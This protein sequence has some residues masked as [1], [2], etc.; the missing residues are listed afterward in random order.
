[1][2]SMAFTQN[3]SF[4]GMIGVMVIGIRR[5]MFSN[6]AGMGNAAIV[7]A[8]SKT[9]EPVREGLVAMLGPF[10]D[11]IIVCV[12][13]ALVVILTGVWNQPAFTQQGGDIGVTLTAAAFRSVI[14]WFPYILTLCIVLFAYSTMI[15]WCYY[16][17]RG[18]IYLLDQC[19]G[20]GL[21]TVVIFR[22]L[23]VVFVVIGA[24][25]PLRDVLDFSDAMIFSMAFPNI[26][27]SMLLAPQVRERV[28]AYWQRIRAENMPVMT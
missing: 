14:P 17:E 22:I 15:S 23:F 11:T 1:M 28:H 2:V 7:H 26:L 27:G 16:G 25:N 9:D 5:A 4:G 20:N 21:R 24:T 8:A 10:I 18:W 12:M 3:A 6:E 13:T 19:G